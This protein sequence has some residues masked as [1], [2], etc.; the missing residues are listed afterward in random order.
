METPEGRQVQV[1]D[2]CTIGRS[3][4]NVVILADERVSRRHALIHV[5]GPGEFWLVD[6]GSSNGTY[7]NRRRV[8]QPTRLLDRDFIQI[9]DFQLTF[10]QPSNAKADDP[11][12]VS[13]EETIADMRAAECWLLV[14]DIVGSSRLA[15]ALSPEQM[16]MLTGGWLAEGKQIVEESAGGIDKFLGDGFFAYWHDC[17]NAFLDVARAIEGMT[18]LQA[19]A[20]PEFRVVVHFGRVC[21]G[22]LAPR[23]NER[24]WGPEVNFAFRMEKLAGALREPR[25]VS[26]PACLRLRSRISATEVGR[27]TLPGYEGAYPFWRF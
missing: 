27:H 13:G 23:G 16:S 24:L 8:Q 11:H 17:E 15:Q 7:L 25:L 14:A 10:H 4:S 2:T 21:L 1:D 26:E 20:R 9:A 6:L 5:Q 22:G 12:T 18:R 19:Q 3:S